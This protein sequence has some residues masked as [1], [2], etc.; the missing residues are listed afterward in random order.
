MSTPFAL[1]ADAPSRASDEQLVERIARR[2]EAAFRALYERYFPRIYRFVA[3]RLSNRADAE[4]TVQEIFINI[5][6]G[7]HGWRREGAF[8][9]WVFGLTRRTVANR[10]KRQRPTA[11]ALD[12]EIPVDSEAC[13]SAVRRESNPLED[14]EC[15]DRLRRLQQAARHDLTQVQWDLFRLHHLQDRSIED[16]AR[17]SCRSEDSVKSHLY[18]ARKTLL[19]R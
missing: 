7:V 11:V 3:R 6:T 16:I 12:E 15:R 1:R 14:Y 2:D 5:F 9:A 8:I 18:R 17:A 13:G 10:F 19:A 4:E